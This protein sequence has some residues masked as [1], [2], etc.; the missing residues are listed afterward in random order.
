VGAGPVDIPSD[1]VQV[2]IDMGDLDAGRV[3]W[4]EA[5]P[6][7]VDREFMTEAMHGFLERLSATAPDLP[8]YLSEGDGERL[9]TS[10]AFC[11]EIGLSPS[12]P[13]QR[14]GT[15]MAAIESAGYEVVIRKKKW[16][17]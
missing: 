14:F 16:P 11:Q 8:R 13:G 6:P 3:K 15:V 17:D 12:A 7:Q 10:I 5:E 4:D 1:L 2:M 9:I